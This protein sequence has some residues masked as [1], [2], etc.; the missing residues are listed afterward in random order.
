MKNNPYRIDQYYKYSLQESHE[1]NKAHK[2]LLFGKFLDQRSEFVYL[3]IIQLIHRNIGTP[4]MP[5]EECAVTVR[6]HNEILR[7][8]PKFL[9]K[10][11]R[12]IDSHDGFDIIRYKHWHEQLTELYNQFK[13]KKPYFNY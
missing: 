4:Y 11:G 12:Y 2:E 10:L 9:K 7:F 8:F 5:Y 13:E 1:L 3:G 6:Q